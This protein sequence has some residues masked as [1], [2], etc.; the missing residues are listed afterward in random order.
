MEAGVNGLV[1]G[2][3]ALVYTDEERAHAAS[4]ERSEARSVLVDWFKATSGQNLSRRFLAML[5]AFTW[6]LMYLVSAGLSVSVVFAPAC[7]PDA[8][9]CLAQQL[10]QASSIIGERADSM[11]GA[12]ML[13]LGFYFAAPHLSSIVGPA[14]SK[15]SK[16]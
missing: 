14:V 8:V 4:A 7:D 2:L 5:I 13:I 16:S 12:M 6:L 10:N 9:Q 3:D 15:F 1:K 11:S